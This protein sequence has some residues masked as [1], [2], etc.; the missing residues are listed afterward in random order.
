MGPTAVNDDAYGPS[1][2]ER[3]AN[4]LGSRLSPTANDL[5][6]LELL[7]EGHIT[8]DMLQQWWDDYDQMKG[9]K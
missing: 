1:I 7:I 3:I 2:W 5:H 8:A 4:R 6:E 9:A